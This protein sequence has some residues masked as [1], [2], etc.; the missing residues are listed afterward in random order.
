M[1]VLSK[2]DNITQK[3]A[4]IL[5]LIG[6]IIGL[7]S[8]PPFFFPSKPEL[9][10]EIISEFDIMDIQKNIP[11]L[12]I[13]YNEKYLSEDNQSLRIIRIRA[14]N[15][16][17]IDITKALYDETLPFGF[18][19]K[20]GEIVSLRPAEYGSEYFK[21]NFKQSLDKNNNTVEYSKIIWD[22]EDFVITDLLV[23]YNKGAYPQ[24]LPIG[25][26]AGISK[27]ST[28]ENTLSR[29]LEKKLVLEKVVELLFRM[30]VSII[31]IIV[32]HS[33]FKEVVKIRDANIYTFVGIVLTVIGVIHF[34]IKNSPK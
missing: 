27:F 7:F 9:T 1:N 12:T 14:R 33:V 34:I 18:T 19:V 25:K 10:F 13:K 31:T 3:W 2:L 32:F 29:W 20:N 23:A 17:D 4:S 22:K 15:S 11:G 5:T 8:V 21:T 16:G 6:F 26:I 24:I 30:L 28:N